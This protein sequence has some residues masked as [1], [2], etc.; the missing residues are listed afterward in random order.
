MRPL[1]G[2]RGGA[3]T[4][5]AAM[6]VEHHGFDTR[7]ADIDSKEHQLTNGSMVGI[8]PSGANF[9]SVTLTLRRWFLLLIC[10]SA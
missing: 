9:S 4:H 8:E 5:H 7:G 6:L 1:H 2:Q 3:L 10:V